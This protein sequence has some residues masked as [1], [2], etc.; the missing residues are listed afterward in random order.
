MFLL[1]LFLKPFLLPPMPWFIMLVVAG[2]FW[3]RRWARVLFWVT[4]I[5]I[6]V[7]HS[8]DIG[9]MLR[10]PLEARYAPLIDPKPAEPYDAIVVLMGGTIPAGGLV[11][12]PTVNDALFHRLDEAWRLY[13]LR[14]KPIIVSGGHVNPLS[15]DR[16]ENQ[17]AC[18]Y[19]LLW[20]LPKNQLIQE[21]YSRDTFENA[22]E[23]GK[24]LREKGWKRYL[25]VT[26]AIHMP[27][28]MF[29]FES[30]APTPI[31]APGDFTY[32][33][34]G[35]YIY[36]AEEAAYKIA[37]AAHEYLGLMNYR[38]RMRGYLREERNSSDTAR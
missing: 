7:L 12:F 1:K 24:I 17:I 27:R 32:A 10:Y 23:V 14:P 20:G 35:P 22:I 25:L 16:G 29:A 33:G 8:P 30:I 18:N 3:R 21:P 38:W 6:F 11:P 9:I 5:V 36:L 28:S 34:G 2:I 19:L 15:K 37:D 26:S 4:V 13:R 31:P